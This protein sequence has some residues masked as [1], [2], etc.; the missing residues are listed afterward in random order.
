ML[1]SMLRYFDRTLSVAFVKYHSTKY[2]H[3]VQI[4]RFDLWTWQLK[5]QNTDKLL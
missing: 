4:S 5:E 2:I 3:F 1:L